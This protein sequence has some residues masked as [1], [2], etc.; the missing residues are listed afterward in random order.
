[1]L[2]SFSPPCHPPDFAKA[3]EYLTRVEFA[4]GRRQ[5]PAPGTLISIKT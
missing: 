1:L 5:R 2:P 3:F 4:A